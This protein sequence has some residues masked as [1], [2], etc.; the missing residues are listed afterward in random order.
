ME[1]RNKQVNMRSRNNGNDRSGRAVNFKNINA[2]VTTGGYDI[3]EPEP[4]NISVNELDTN[5]YTC[6]LSSNFTLLRMTSR[7]ADA[8]VET[9]RDSYIGRNP[10]PK[11]RTHN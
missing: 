5:A 8:Y 1:G 11:L 3:E 4:G 6:C 10:L 9:S 2:Q 7:T